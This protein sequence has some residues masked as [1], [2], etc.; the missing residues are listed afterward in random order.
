[1]RLLILV[2]W[3]IMWLEKPDNHSS[4]SRVVALPLVTRGPISIVHLACWRAFE[5]VIESLAASGF[6]LLMCPLCSDLFHGIRVGGE[7]PCRDQWNIRLLFPSVVETISVTI[8]YL[9]WF[10]LKRVLS[11]I[12]CSILSWDNGAV[13]KITWAHFLHVTTPE[14][15]LKW[16]FCISTAITYVCCFQWIIPN[17]DTIFFQ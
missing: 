9:V 8:Y 17:R 7:F 13:S 3:N 4:R 11:E 12:L 15:H 16:S 14:F 5:Q 10:G 6:L 1:M 2:L